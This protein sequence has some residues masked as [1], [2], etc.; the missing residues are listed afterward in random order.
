MTVLCPSL[1]TD[2]A[3]GTLLPERGSAYEI[4]E[5]CAVSY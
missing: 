5:K 2:I 3:P 1:Y 4:T